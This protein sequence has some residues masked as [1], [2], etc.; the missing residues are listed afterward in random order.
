MSTMDDYEVKLTQA[1]YTADG[2][3]LSPE[4]SARAAKVAANMLKQMEA[5]LFAA[6]TGPSRKRR[7]RVVRARGSDFE[8]VELDEAGKIIEPLRC[9]C[10][11]MI[12]IHGPRCPF[13]C[14]T[15]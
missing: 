4:D 11:G 14:L 12:V 5:E 9:T 7:Q 1:I 8:T 13:Y 15:T 10:D 6:I 3:Y 2:L